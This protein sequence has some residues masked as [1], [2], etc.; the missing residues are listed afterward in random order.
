MKKE[1]MEL[2][3]CLKPRPKVVLEIGMANGGNFFFVSLNALLSSGLFDFK[4]YS[5]VAFK[6]FPVRVFLDDTH[7]RSD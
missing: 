2:L 1:M 6:Y 4:H 3:K 5:W 7:G